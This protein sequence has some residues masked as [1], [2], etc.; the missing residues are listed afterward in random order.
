MQPG[1]RVDRE[2]HSA[3]K[4]DVLHHRHAFD[5]LSFLL[6]AFEYNLLLPGS[7]RDC[8]REKTAVLA[9]KP[10]AREGRGRGE[11]RCQSLVG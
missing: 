4:R 3:R 6:D 10:S 7:S 9:H 2:R 1:H 5:A 11:W 8:G